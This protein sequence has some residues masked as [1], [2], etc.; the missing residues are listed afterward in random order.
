MMC[1]W[2]S[3]SFCTSF[4]YRSKMCTNKAY[5]N[6]HEVRVF[7]LTGADSDRRHLRE[8]GKSVRENNSLV[9]HQ[10]QWFHKAQSTA[11]WV[12]WTSMTTSMHAL[13]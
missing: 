5:S 13:L 10:L 8:I 2:N 6:V 9:W 3:L 4:I 7:A 11:T 12:E 1:V